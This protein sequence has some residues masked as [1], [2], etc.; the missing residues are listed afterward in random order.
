M[1]PAKLLFAVV[2]ALQASAILAQ[3][4]SC[5][6]CETVAPPCYASR[7]YAW[8]IKD[9]CSSQSLWNSVQ[10]SSDVRSSVLAVW[11]PGTP[12]STTSFQSYVL[13][14]ANNRRNPSCVKT[15]LLD[16]IKCKAAPTDSAVQFYNSALGVGVSGVKDVRSLNTFVTAVIKKIGQTVFNTLAGML[17]QRGLQAQPI[18]MVLA[19]VLT[20]SARRGASKSRPVSLASRLSPP[21]STPSAINT[22]PFAAPHACSGAAALRP[23][24]GMPPLLPFAAAGAVASSSTLAGVAGAGSPS[25]VACGP[26]LTEGIDSSP[27]APAA[28]VF[29]QVTCLTTVYCADKA[30]EEAAQA[31]QVGPAYLYVPFPLSSTLTAPTSPVIE[32]ERLQAEA[33]K[34]SEFE[35]LKKQHKQGKLGPPTSTITPRYQLVIE[36]ER[37]QAEALK[38]GGFE[39]IRKQ[40]KQGKL[41]A[42]E[43][44]MT[45]LDPGSFEELGE[46]RGSA[47]QASVAGQ[48]KVAARERVMTVLVPGLTEEVDMLVQHRCRDFGMDETQ[49]AGDGVVTG[50]GTINGRLV[51]VFSQDF[52]V[53]GGSLSETH[54]S[55]IVKIME[56]AMLVGAPVIGINDSGGA[57][58]QEGVVSLAG[59]ANVFQL[60]VLASGVIPQLS[61][62]MGPCAGGAVYS[63]ALTDF[64]AMT[65]GTAYMF[66]TGPDVVKQV[67]FEDVTRD[68]LGGADVQS[69]SGVVHL[70]YDNELDA[71]ARIRDL[72]DFLPLSNQHA[73]PLRPNFDS[74]N[75]VSPSLDFAVPRDPNTAYDMV[76][77]IEQVVDDGE[78]FEVQGGFAR[79]ILIGF[80]RLDGGTVGVVANQPKEQ[81]GCLDIN[82]SIKGARFV[83]FCDAFNIPILTFVDVPGF[84]PGTEQEHNGIIRQGAK[85]LYAYAEA[86][87]PKLTVITRKAYGGAY[88]VMSSKHLRGDAN[89][90]WPSAEIAVM[91]AKG[92]AEILHRGSVDLESLTAEYTRKFANPYS[93]A[94]LGYVDAVIMPR[95]TR[96]VLCKEMARLRNK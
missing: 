18:G 51:F 73:P 70:A 57:R 55:K 80:A 48:G 65:R 77:I 11:G 91:G 32:L 86:T 37:L 56:K 14:A 24:A 84:L 39:R 83:R 40:H 78:L 13:M 72:F 66:V 20:G 44:I 45:L 93:A 30:D 28:H 59:Y 38:G 3:T 74:P 58:I 47:V 5:A 8:W 17:R 95:D 68:E 22:T 46:W 89:Y 62:I 25:G 88:D 49:I 33:L 50:S 9:D 7:W 41:T 85:L 4:C 94:Q 82:A 87:V 12:G 19:R 61:L 53:F 75:R 90:A 29:K 67:T 10:S 2:V 6:D 26:Q 15:Y 92:A 69:K 21:I 35:R 27:S 54:A 76:E 36:L 63:P 31:G 34:D 96:K 1:A 60:N 52:T 42:R 64:V 71:L 43:R 81:A 16:W 23:I 79:N